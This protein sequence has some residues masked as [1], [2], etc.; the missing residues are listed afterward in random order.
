MNV[1]VLH[2][3]VNLYNNGF[4]GGFVAAFLVP[5]I[6]AVS[7]VAGAPRSRRKV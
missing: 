6:E 1:G 4:S 5:I 3:G 7:P 2:G